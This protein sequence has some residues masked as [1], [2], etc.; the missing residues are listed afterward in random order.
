MFATSKAPG[1]LNRWGNWLVLFCL[2]LATI[3]L[4]RSLEEVL[5]G[6]TK[7]NRHLPD[8]TIKKFKTTQLDEHGRLKNL[9]AAETMT[10][11][12]EANATLT[13]PYLVFFKEKEPTWTVRAE[14][15]EVSPDGN[16]VWLLGDTTVLRHAQE[17]TTKILSQDVRVQIDTEYAE[18]VAPTTI[19]SG[20]NKTHSVGMHLFMSTERVELF[21][22]VRGYHVLP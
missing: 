15:G 10:H 4:V 18:T 21:S 2:V 1:M 7:I 9:L 17:Q 13:A 3:W 20:N 8:Y 16:Q 12:P 22:Q 5:S 14:Q 19:I 6:T 11:F